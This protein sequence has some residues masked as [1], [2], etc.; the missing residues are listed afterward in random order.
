[1]LCTL[2]IPHLSVD[3]LALI[4]PDIAKAIFDTLGIE[5][6][7]ENIAKLS[8]SDRSIRR[9]RDTCMQAT[10]LNGNKELAMFKSLGESSDGATRGGGGEN[11]A[12]GMPAVRRSGRGGRTD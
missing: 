12:Q 10:I 2:K 4:I 8:P 1:M 3:G 6:S 11:G 5:V 9:W 7:N